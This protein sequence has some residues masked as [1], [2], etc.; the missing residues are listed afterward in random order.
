MV[1]MTVFLGIPTDITRNDTQTERETGCISSENE[2]T[3]ELTA[4]VT[5]LEVMATLRAGNDD[6]A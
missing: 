4:C 5:L 1:L 2:D 3:A 6:A